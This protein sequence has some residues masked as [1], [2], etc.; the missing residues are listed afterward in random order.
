MFHEYIYLSDL[1]VRTI[2]T[3]YSYTPKTPTVT[4]KLSV[5]FLRHVSLFV[6]K[7]CLFYSIVY[8]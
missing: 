8:R 2:Y 1:R 5:D 7:V 6:G 4:V 3:Q